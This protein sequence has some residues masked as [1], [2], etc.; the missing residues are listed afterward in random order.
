ML[1]GY[2]TCLFQLHYLDT[3]Q[4]LSQNSTVIQKPHYA[5]WLLLVEYTETFCINSLFHLPLSKKL[6]Y[7]IW[8]YTPDLKT[9]NRDFY[10]CTNSPD[11]SLVHICHTPQLCSK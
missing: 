6:I 1:E 10:M 8:N 9:S 11:I 4:T 3:L 7:E 5:I 2:R